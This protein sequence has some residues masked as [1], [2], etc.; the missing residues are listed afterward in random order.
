MRDTRVPPG[1]SISSQLHPAFTLYRLRF[2]PVDL[3]VCTI[4]CPFC[5]KQYVEATRV[6]ATCVETTHVKGEVSITTDR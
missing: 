4:D 6:E 2:I 3:G 1:A 5:D